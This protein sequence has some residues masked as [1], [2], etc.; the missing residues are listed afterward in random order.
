LTRAFPE[1]VRALRERFVDVVLDGVIWRRRRRVQ[2]VGD[3][4]ALLAPKC[5]GAYLQ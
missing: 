3:G 5:R 2:N 4:A 1:I